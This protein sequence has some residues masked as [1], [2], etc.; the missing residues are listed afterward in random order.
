MCILLF[1]IRLAIITFLDICYSKNSKKSSSSRLG[2]AAQCFLEVSANSNSTSPLVVSRKRLHDDQKSDLNEI[3]EDLDSR[4]IHQKQPVLMA[5]YKDHSLAEIVSMC[6]PL[7]SGITDIHFTLDGTGPATT[8]ATLKYTWPQVM[9][10][11]EG[12]LHL[13]FKKK[14]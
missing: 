14:L 13:L 12:Y 3:I 10:N 7:S 11:I 8:L 2:T 9:F 6:V 1:S 5:V 4:L